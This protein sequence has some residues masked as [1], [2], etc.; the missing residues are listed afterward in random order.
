MKSR[1]V[2]R[3]SAAHREYSAPPLVMVE[4]WTIKG[5]YVVAASHNR[6]QADAHSLHRHGNCGGF[7]NDN[8]VK[9]S[10]QSQVRCMHFWHP[11]PEESTGVHPSHITGGQP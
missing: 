10:L 9:S 5:M 2:A 8:Q 3:V 6:R 11:G 1:D 4:F 7:D